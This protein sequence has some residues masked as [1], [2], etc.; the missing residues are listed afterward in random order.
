MPPNA[1]YTTERKEEF[2]KMTRSGEVENW[3]R[4]YAT[5]KGG[6]YFH[7]EVRDADL[8]TAPQLL[9]AKARQLDSI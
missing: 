6:T 9:A 8:A 3:V 7:I 4:V 5:S 2:R 1:D